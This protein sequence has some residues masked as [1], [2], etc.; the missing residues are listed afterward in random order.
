MCHSL[1]VL[2][3]L[4]TLTRTS[5]R[6]LGTPWTFLYFEA[7]IVEK[8]TTLR[9]DDSAASVELVGPATA[10]KIYS[11]PKARNASPDVPT[12][13]SFVGGQKICESP[14]YFILTM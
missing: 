6:P 11:Q 10:I 14:L 7:G 8:E 4:P 1:Y 9:A 2:G 3:P 13:V 12:Q 5:R